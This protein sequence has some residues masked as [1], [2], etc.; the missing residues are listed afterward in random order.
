[1]DLLRLDWNEEASSGDGSNSNTNSF[2]GEKLIGREKECQILRQLRDQVQQPNQPSA[3]VVIHGP[4]GS[5]KTALC[6][7]TILEATTNNSNSN[8]SNSSSNDN[9][10][11]CCYCISG[12]FDQHH[13]DFSLPYSALVQAFDGLG[14][15]LLEQ[16]RQNGNTSKN[17]TTN[18]GESNNVD[19]LR[20]AIRTSLSMEN[21]SLLLLRLIPSFQRLYDD[22]NDKNNK[23]DEEEKVVNDQATPS[24]PSS[25]ITSSILTRSTSSSSSMTSQSEMSSG[26]SEEGFL[27]SERLAVAFRSFLATF[28]CHERPLLLM[29]DDV[30]WADPNSA[31]V[32]SSIINSHD[33]TNVLF[34]VCFRDD[35]DDDGDNVREGNDGNGNR[36]R[37]RTEFCNSLKKYQSIPVRNLDQHGVS[38]L[39]RKVLQTSQDIEELAQ[40]IHQKTLGNPYFCLQILTLLHRSSLLTYHV[41]RL[42]WEWNTA[43]IQSLDVADNVADVV[44]K[45]LQRIPQEC[46]RLLSLISCLG[47]YTTLDILTLIWK[48]NI[49]FDEAG[50]GGDDD[51]PDLDEDAS[52]DR[53]DQMLASVESEGFLERL[54]ND[55]GQAATVKFSHDRFQETAY[56]LIDD[57][58][59]QRVH[60]K[61]GNALLTLLEEEDS[62]PSQK[63]SGKK[64]QQQQGAS[65]GDDETII[66]TTADQLNRGCSCLES[67][68]DRMKLIVLNFRASKLAGKKSSFKLVAFFLQKA[69]ALS[70]DDDWNSQR[71]YNLMLGI[72]SR[73]VEVEAARGNFDRA[74]DLVSIILSKAKSPV[75]CRRART[76]NAQAYGWKFQFDLAIA[77]VREVIK[78][79]GE[80]LAPSS[81]RSVKEE[82]TKLRR[83]LEKFTN[84]ELLSLP[85]M[86]DPLKITCMKVL[87]LGMPFGWSSDPAFKDLCLLKSMECTLKY[88]HCVPT[89]GFA[90]SGYGCVLSD[91]LEFRSEAFRF[92]RISLQVPHARSSVPANALNVYCFLAHIK[93]PVSLSV[94]P[95]IKAY[96]VGLETGDHSFGSICCS[97]YVSRRINIHSIFLITSIYPL[98]HV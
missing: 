39:V 56:N 46:R 84:E 20:S 95:M 10:S 1:M 43:E 19:I 62:S 64:K 38:Q 8:N 54:H 47:Y 33:C 90:Y 49:I 97:I 70:N 40:I 48:S 18:N 12:K 22:V 83:R 7:H 30:Q 41:G 36:K 26:E 53:L 17:T 50:K 82:T 32:L 87:K 89:G 77:E 13:Q 29:I 68:T 37:T 88:G 91:T 31:Q 65:G 81:A 94:D 80:E 4:S 28:C 85:P 79:C 3:T 11:D 14:Q 15:R 69:I 74:E 57:E 23:E 66:Y 75:D 59:R 61:I 55:D 35:D 67:E 86:T 71:W 34:A 98:K 78:L 16:I 42:Q 21:A 27:A 2:C 73:A 60:W 25:S 51:V 72:H 58:Q 44:L 52:S 63:H 93:L 45:R 96:Q 9:G 92:S 76:A 6:R 24:S 5:G